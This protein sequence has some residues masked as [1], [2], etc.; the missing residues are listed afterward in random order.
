M[1]RRKL[2]GTIEDRAGV[3]DEGYVPPSDV[4]EEPAELTG[5]EDHRASGL[6]LFVSFL[7]PIAG[8]GLAVWRLAR[9]DVGPG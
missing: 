6:E 3:E 7:I 9:N 5:D 4:A 8:L 1:A 2:F